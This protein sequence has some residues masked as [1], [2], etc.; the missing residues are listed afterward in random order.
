MNSSVAALLGVILGAVLKSLA[1]WFTRREA[2]RHQ[3]DMDKRELAGRF[4]GVMHSWEHGANG[5]RDADRTINELRIVA[6]PATVDAAERYRDALK[7]LHWNVDNN[8]GGPEEMEEMWEAGTPELERLRA[9]F[10]D[11]ARNEIH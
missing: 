2:R 10:V 4:L 3:F 7:A 9:D 11:A 1:D 5:G 6:G 8:A